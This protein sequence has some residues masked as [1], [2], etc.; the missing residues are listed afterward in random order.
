MDVCSWPNGSLNFAKVP[1]TENRLVKQ[2]K[3]F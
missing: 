2:E 3:I 1:K